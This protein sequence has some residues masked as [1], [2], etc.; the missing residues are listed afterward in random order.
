MSR[1]YRLGD[2]SEYKVELALLELAEDG[3]VL[4]EKGLR[5]LSFEHAKPNSKLDLRYT[6][7]LV[8]VE[9][10]EQ[11]LVPVPIQVKSS[12]R[13]RRDFEVRMDMAK[14]PNIRSV[15]VHLGEDVTKVKEKVIQCLK[16]AVDFFK[17]GSSYLFDEFWQFVPTDH[18]FRKKEI[19]ARRRRLSR[20][21]ERTLNPSKFAFS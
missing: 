14:T 16:T 13:K 10:D 17:H 1:T 4:L 3:S 5:I 12:E 2:S 20:Y 21:F 15:A 6:D 8:L 9:T 19:R 7:F 11:E 18:V